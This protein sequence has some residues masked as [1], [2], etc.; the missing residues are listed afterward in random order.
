MTVFQMMKNLSFCVTP[1]VELNFDKLLGFLR[2]INRGY[3]EDVAY[4]NDLHGA[5]VA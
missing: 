5:D 3:R 1:T 4:H 2:A